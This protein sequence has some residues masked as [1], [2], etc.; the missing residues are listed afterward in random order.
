MPEANPGDPRPSVKGLAVERPYMHTGVII[1][2]LFGLD[3]VVVPET[4]VREH[5]DPETFENVNTREDLEAAAR[6]L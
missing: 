3:Y 4:E 6:R 1:E 5:A 2:P